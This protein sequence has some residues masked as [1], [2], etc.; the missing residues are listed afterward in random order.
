MVAT[1]AI[2]IPQKYAHYKPGYL[3]IPEWEKIASGER[4]L[5][6]KEPSVSF[7]ARED[8]LTKVECGILGNKIENLYNDLNETEARPHQFPW[9]VGLFLVTIISALAMSFPANIS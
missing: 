6:Q 1:T 9:Q 4:K 3:R 7:K 8:I 2:H 5:K